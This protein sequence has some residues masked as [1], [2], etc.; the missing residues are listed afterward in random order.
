VPAQSRVDVDIVARVRGAGGTLELTHQ[1][2]EKLRGT[3]VKRVLS[4]VGSG[5]EVVIRYSLATPRKMGSLRFKLSTTARGGVGL[6]V[7]LVEASVHIRPLEQPV[8]QIQDLRKPRFVVRP[9]AQP[10]GS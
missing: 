5:D 8:T 2:Q 3:H 1:L 9:A 7:E 10:D 6:S 4:G